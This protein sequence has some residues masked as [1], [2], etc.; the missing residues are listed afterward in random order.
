M[1]LNK[2]SENILDFVTKSDQKPMTLDTIR[3]TTTWQARGDRAEPEISIRG[4]KWAFPCLNCKCPDLSI[5]TGTHGVTL[6]GDRGPES[7]LTR[8]SRL[9]AYFLSDDW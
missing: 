3:E 5:K 7:L 4:K 6:R 2:K 9:L 1:D 8:G